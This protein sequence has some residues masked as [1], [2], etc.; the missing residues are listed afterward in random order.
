LR[1]SNID[2][3]H[4]AELPNISRFLDDREMARR[5][6]DLVIASSETLKAK[7]TIEHVI[8][9]ESWLTSSQLHWYGAG[10]L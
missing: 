8:G 6:I 4:Y 9:S 10:G 3:A 1:I 2:G 5:V 7:G